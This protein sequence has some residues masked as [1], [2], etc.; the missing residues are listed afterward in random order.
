[1]RLMPF[2]IKQTGATSGLS[3]P[4]RVAWL[5][6]FFPHDNTHPQTAICIRSNGA[7]WQH[8]AGSIRERYQSIIGRGVQ[9][10]ARVSRCAAALV[11][12]QLAVFLVTDREG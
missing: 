5:R 10:I 3:T 4:I 7:L 8:Q 1:M 6:P 9:Q 2:E 11:L 12:I